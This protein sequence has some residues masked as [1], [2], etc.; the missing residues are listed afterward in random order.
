VNP[1]PDATWPLIAPPSAPYAGDELI[2]P[3][4]PEDPAAAALL[5]AHREV[6]LGQ[7]AP[8]DPLLRGLASEAGVLAPEPPVERLFVQRLPVAPLLPCDSWLTDLA[9]DVIPDL[10]LSSAERVLGPMAEEGPS[11]RARRVAAGVMAFA[12][13]NPPRIRPFDR[14]TKDRRGGTDQER[15][16][17]RAVDRAPAMCWTVEAPGQP[18]PVLPMDPRMLPDGPVRLLPDRQGGSPGLMPAG[19]W[20]ARVMRG[21]G[22]W[23]AALALPLDTPPDPTWLLARMTLELWQLRCFVPEADWIMLLRERAEVLYRCCH[24]WAW[25]AREVAL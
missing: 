25:T 20:L 24:E 6:L 19:C 9:E 13:Y 16:S 11:R 7:R 21:P 2:E 3:P 10:G 23:H 12:L 8:L 22:G 17:L 4:T 14:W 5:A 1:P 15:A 18:A